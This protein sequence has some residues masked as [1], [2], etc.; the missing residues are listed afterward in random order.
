VKK[1]WES[2]THLIRKSLFPPNYFAA[3]QG[4]VRPDEIGAVLIEG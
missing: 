4:A 3:D 1:D 2:I